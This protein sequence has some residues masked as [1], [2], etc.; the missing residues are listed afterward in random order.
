MS[1]PDDVRD[2]FEWVSEV[3]TELAGQ[4]PRKKARAWLYREAFYDRVHTAGEAVLLALDPQTGFKVVS[5]WGKVCTRAE[6]DERAA[7]VVAFRA[8]RS[9]DVSIGTQ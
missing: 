3:D 2:W 9:G 8:K 7:R 1:A 5:D 4:T 6:E